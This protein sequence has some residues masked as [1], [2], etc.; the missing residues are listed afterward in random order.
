MRNDTFH[1][2]PVLDVLDNIHRALA[3]QP[4]AIADV[5]ADMGVAGILNKNM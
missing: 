2:G 1:W 3:S 5:A 4:E